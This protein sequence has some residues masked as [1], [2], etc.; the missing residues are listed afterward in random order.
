MLQRHMAA[1]FMSAL[2][3][4]KWQLL[5]FKVTEENHVLQVPRLPHFLLHSFI[6]L[7]LASR[8]FG[9]AS[10]STMVSTI[11]PSTLTTIDG[12]TSVRDVA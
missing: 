8:K 12:E 11:D 7:F 2:A 5:S 4:A 3:G 1:L 9:F 6:F 10:I